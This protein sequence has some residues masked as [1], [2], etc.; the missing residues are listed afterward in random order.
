MAGLARGSSGESSSRFSMYS[1]VC[2]SNGGTSSKPTNQ[3]CERVAWFQGG[4]V[5]AEHTEAGDRRLAVGRGDPPVQQA[6]HLRRDHRLALNLEAA[7]LEAR[8]ELAELRSPSRSSN[9]PLRGKA[10]RRL[11]PSAIS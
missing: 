5:H 7:R 4:A 2:T 3:R 10:M 9:G 11:G 6:H 1:S 8:L